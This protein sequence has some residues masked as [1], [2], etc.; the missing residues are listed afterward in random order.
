MATRA[1]QNSPAALGIETVNVVRRRVSPGQGLMRKVKVS[2]A[3]VHFVE[4]EDRGEPVLA[5]GALPGAAPRPF[6]SKPGGFKRPSIS[7]G[8]YK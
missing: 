8:K 5:G 4:P 7:R 1:D 2:L 6:L 3:R